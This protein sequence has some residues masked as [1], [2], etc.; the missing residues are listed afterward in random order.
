MKTP[1]LTLTPFPIF[2]PFSII[3]LGPIYELGSIFFVSIKAE[4]VMPDFFN[5]FLQCPNLENEIFQELNYVFTKI[6]AF[7][8]LFF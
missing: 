5:S 6:L 8:K 1:P 4:D 3:T 2:A 7:I